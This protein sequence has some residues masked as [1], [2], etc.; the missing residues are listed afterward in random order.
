MAS[1]WKVNGGDIYVDEYKEGIKPRVAEHNPI[2]ATNSYYHKIYVPDD[3]ITIAGHVVGK[4]HLTTIKGGV[5]DLV[6]LVSDSGG[7][8][9]GGMTMLLED[10]NAQRLISVCQTIDT[11]QDEDAPIFR[12]TLILRR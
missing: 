2:N 12:V 11:T 9:S 7:P 5:G 1:I 6:T 3:V 10:Y 4:T 8:A